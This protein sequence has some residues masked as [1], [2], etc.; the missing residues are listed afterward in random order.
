[1][2]FDCALP[3]IPALLISCKSFQGTVPQ[4]R[5]DQRLCVSQPA[6]ILMFFLPSVFIDLL[7]LLFF[8]YFH[9][10]LYFLSKVSFCCCFRI[11]LF[12]GG[13]GRKGT[14]LLSVSSFWPSCLHRAYIVYVYRDKAKSTMTKNKEKSRRILFSCV[15]DYLVV[16]FH[17]EL[18]PSG[19]VFDTKTQFKETPYR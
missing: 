6:G 1:M 4:R 9:E 12:S 8:N 5:M 7:F 17:L 2:L 16:F 14:S 18:L 10:S 11:I 19:G 15:L 13:M 3:H